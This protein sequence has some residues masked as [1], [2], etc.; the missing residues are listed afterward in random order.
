MSAHNTCLIYFNVHAH[1]SPPLFF[2]WFMMS[3]YAYHHIS[4]PSRNTKIVAAVIMGQVLSILLCGTGVTTQLLVSKHSTSVPTTQAFINYVLLGLV[5][6]VMVAARK[7]FLTILR[8]NWWKYI[9]LGVVDVE[10]NYLIILAYKYTNLT[11]VQVQ[12]YNGDTIMG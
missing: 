10:A 5:Y 2:I 3:T 8:K 11:T 6:G 1:T 9:I 4:R 7:D 12:E